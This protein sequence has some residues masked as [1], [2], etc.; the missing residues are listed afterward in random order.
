MEGRGPPLPRERSLLLIASSQLPYLPLDRL[1]I[2]NWHNLF[3]QPFNKPRNVGSRARFPSGPD[4]SN[5]GGK[6]SS[7]S[8][9]YYRGRRR[10]EAS[11]AAGIRKF[12]GYL[13]VDFGYASKGLLYTQCY[14]ITGNGTTHRL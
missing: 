14:F 1:D 6:V 2:P 9:L 12:L 11:I 13:R 4:S 10:P 3:K 7:S 8:G 5:R